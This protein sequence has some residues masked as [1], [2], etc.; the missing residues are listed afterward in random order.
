MLALRGLE[1]EV[2]RERLAQVNGWRRRTRVHSRC[3]RYLS[4]RGGLPNRRRMGQ[5][6]CRQSRRRREACEPTHARSDRAAPASPRAPQ[7]DAFRSA[8]R[9]RNSETRRWACLEGYRALEGPYGPSRRW[10]MGPVAPGQSSHLG[11]SREPPR[12]A[13]RVNLFTG[14]GAAWLARLTGGQEVGSSNLPSPTTKMQVDWVKWTADEVVRFF[15]PYRQPYKSPIFLPQ[16]SC[17]EDSVGRR[18]ETA[19]GDREGAN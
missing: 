2:T 12:P 3:R 19:S 13:A 6:T 5:R 9:T 15:C 14:C 10:G 16:R 4:H 11:P 18:P 7:D 8:P 1:S 17:A